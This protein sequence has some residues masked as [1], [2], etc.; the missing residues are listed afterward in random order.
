[1]ERNQEM[2]G[3]QSLHQFKIYLGMLFSPGAH[4]YTQFSKFSICTT[5]GN[6][7]LVNSCLQSS[8]ACSS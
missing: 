2:P 8:A 7:F 5:L 6:A 4:W 3:P 1:M